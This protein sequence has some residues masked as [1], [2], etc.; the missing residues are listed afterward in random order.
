MASG[1]PGFRPASCL[2]DPDDQCMRLVHP[3]R[4]SLNGMGLILLQEM[5]FALVVRVS[6][7]AMVYMSIV[8]ASLAWAIWVQ[9]GFDSY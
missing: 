3:F 9:L 5:S 2:N 4:E 7:I 1:S 8:A 6:S